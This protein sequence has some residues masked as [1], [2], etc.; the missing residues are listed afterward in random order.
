M[1]KLF[2]VFFTLAFIFGHFARIEFGNGVALVAID[3]VVG[4][5]AAYWFG[6]T[7]VVRKK[8]TSPLLLPTLVFTG[9]AVQ[10]LVLSLLLFSPIQ[11]LIGSLYLLRFLSYI[12]MYFFIREFSKD[13]RRNLLKGLVVIIGVTVTI[14]AFQYLYYPS[15]R[16][17]FYLGWDDHLYR[18]FSVFLDPNFTGALFVCFFLFLLY[19]FKEFRKQS[20]IKQISLVFFI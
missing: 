20:R 2:V 17:L 12:G 10:S 14:G 1:N 19:F 13:D 9:I 8:I 3:I 6:K 7:I 15:L 4:F 18:L 11:V 16:N 5:F